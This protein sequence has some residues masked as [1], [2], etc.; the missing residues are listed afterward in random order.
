MT[1]PQVRVR[2]TVSDLW[3]AIARILRP[4]GRRGEVVAE[5]LTDFPDR[6]EKLKRAFLETPAGPPQPIDIAEVW[7]H[8]E[9]LILRFEGTE[10][11][12]QAR[13]LQGRLLL[14]PGEQRVK[15]G[16]DQYYISDLIGCQVLSNE[17]R[18]GEVIRVEP[19]GGADLLC[20]RPAE[21][22]KNSSEILIPFAQEICPEVDVVA[23]RIVIEP[24][25]GLLALNDEGAGNS[26]T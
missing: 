23:R 21:G 3:L 8:A 13:Q 1:A 20:V 7:W 5:V 4:R 2:N 12:D 17:R 24:P 10:S 15:L 11:I 19:T 25:E 9:R 6:F 14:V 26:E 16:A 18:I 22:A